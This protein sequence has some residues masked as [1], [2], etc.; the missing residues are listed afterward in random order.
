MLKK[1]QASEALS[2]RFNQ[3]EQDIIAEMLPDSG[4]FFNSSEMTLVRFQEMMRKMTNDVAFRRA[5]LGGNLSPAIRD[6]AGQLIGGNK[7]LKIQRIPTGAVNDP[8]VFSSNG[9]YDYLGLLAGKGVNISEQHIKFTAAEA[10]A[11]GIPVP[12]GAA[13]VTIQLKNLPTP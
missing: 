13:S 11:R 9:H 8:F 5:E 10:T 1:V 6:T 7:A 4:A 3:R 2:E 12:A